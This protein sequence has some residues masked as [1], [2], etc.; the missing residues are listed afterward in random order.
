VARTLPKTSAEPAEA[1]STRRFAFGLYL[2]FVLSWFLHL[3]ARFPAL[4]TLRLDLLL[5]VIITGLIVMTK[6]EGPKSGDRQISRLIL[7]LAGYAILT[8]PFVQWPGS[9]I[10]TGIPNFVKAFV[11]YYFTV[12]L[13]TSDS[14]L[15]KL[16]WVFVGGQAFRVLEPLFLHITTGYWGSVTT[17]LDSSGDM[18]SLDRLAG[19]PSDI[20]NPNGLAFVI[21]T[22]IPFLHYLGTATKFGSF[23]YLGYLG[24]GL[25][26]LMLTASRSGMLALAMTGLMIWKN[27]SRKFM[28]A[29]ALAVIV[30]ASVPFLTD[31]LADRYLSIVSSKTKNSHSAEGRINGVTADL[32]VALRRP[33][34][35]HGLGTSLEANANFGGAAMPSHNLY[36]QVAQELG[37]VG[38]AIFVVFLFT[39]AKTVNQTLREFRASGINTGLY[40]RLSLAVQV[41]FGMNILFSFASYGLSSYEWYF[42]AGLAELLR[43]YADSVK[44]TEKIPV[45]AAAPL[46]NFRVQP[47]HF[48]AQ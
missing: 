28:M 43:R 46:R 10:N 32:K 26:A 48:H 3:T 35:G 22:V 39:V 1:S 24:A 42:L 45:P 23:L 47:A 14:Q 18:T 5:V 37:F 9:V 29:A 11:F 27:S 34:L 21:L 31:D 41:W 20:I 36:T 2:L 16:L 8:T 4:G 44:V 6:Q 25:F 19:G 38:L 17:M 13:V 7:G 30:M 33:L 12:E 40:Y 15:R